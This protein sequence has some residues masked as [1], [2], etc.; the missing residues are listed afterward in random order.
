ML[1]CR[2]VRLRISYRTWPQI[3][4][5]FTR[6]LPPNHT[7]TKYEC[8]IGR[9]SGRPFAAVTACLD[10]STHSHLLKNPAEV[11]GNPSNQMHVLPLYRVTAPPSLSSL[12]PGLKLN[13]HY[14][15]ISA[16]LDSDDDDEVQGQSR[17]EVRGQSH[18]EV[19]GQSSYEIQAK[20]GFE[21]NNQPGY[22]AKP[23]QIPT[24]A[25]EIHG[26]V[27]H[28]PFLGVD[29]G[30]HEYLSPDSSGLGSSIE[31]VES[32]MPLGNTEVLAMCS[33]SYPL[34]GY[35][36][37]YEGDTSQPD[38]TDQGLSQGLSQGDDLFAEVALSNCDESNTTLNE[39]IP[40]PLDNTSSTLNDSILGP[41]DTSSSTL[42]GSMSGPSEAIIQ[43]VKG[44]ASAKEKQQRVI[45]VLDSIGAE[46]VALG[47]THGSILIECAKKEIHA[48][49][50]LKHPSRLN[51]SRISLVFYQHIALNEPHHAFYTRG[52]E[53]EQKCEA[54]KKA[55]KQRAAENNQARDGS[56]LPDKEDS[57][58]QIGQ[59][60][61][62]SPPK[63][64]SPSPPKLSST[65][66]KKSVLSKTTAAKNTPLS[67]DGTQMESQMSHDESFTPV[68]IPRLPESDTQ[69]VL[70]RHADNSLR[71]LEPGY[72]AQSPAVSLTLTSP[73]LPF[74]PPVENNSAFPSSGQ[75][76][77]DP[78]ANSSRQC[79]FPV[80]ASPVNLFSDHI[81][82]I[83][84]PYLGVNGQNTGHMNA[85]Q[86]IPYP[87]PYPIAPEFAYRRQK[88]PI[89]FSAYP[90]GYYSP[91]QLRQ[92][93]VP[94][95]AAQTMQ[96]QLSVHGSGAYPAAGQ[97]KQPRVDNL[98]QPS[99]PIIRSAPLPGIRQFYY[100]QS[101]DASMS[102]DTDSLFSL[103]WHDAYNSGGNEFNAT[104]R[105]N[106]MGS[107]STSEETSDAEVMQYE[108]PATLQQQ[109]QQQQHQLIQNMSHRNQIRQFMT[110][111]TNAAQ[112]QTPVVPGIQQQQQLMQIFPQ[113]HQDHT[114]YT[115]TV[116]A[117]TPIMPGFQQQQQQ[118]FQ[119]V[120][121]RDQ[122]HQ[123]ITN[124]ADTA[125]AETPIVSGFQQQQQQLIQTIPQ[126]HQD[127]QSVTNYKEQ[128]QTATVLGLQSAPPSEA[129][130]NT[131]SSRSLTLGQSYQEIPS[132]Q[133]PYGRVPTI[134]SPQGHSQSTSLYLQSQG[135]S[136]QSVP[137]ARLD[138][139][140]QPIP[141]SQ[142]AYQHMSTTVQ[143]SQDGYSSGS[144]GPGSL[145]SI[146]NPSSYA[147]LLHPNGMSQPVGYNQPSVARW[148][149]PYSFCFVPSNA[150]KLNHQVPGVIPQR[151]AVGSAVTQTHSNSFPR[152]QFQFSGQGTVPTT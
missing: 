82:A 105:A 58:S 38:W 114:N 50:G 78:I 125:Q 112:A 71:Y 54:T 73:N 40:G 149:N 51:P 63:K 135:D 15:I 96:S 100:G 127:H 94:M 129:S 139:P 123:S 65:P 31:S 7:R 11:S 52:V 69:W 104:A 76:V 151:N 37:G 47:L 113:N 19:R 23:S 106:T 108:T 99:T 83:C 90:M 102:S 59:Q 98:L 79:P 48:T 72:P 10:Y 128:A 42:N 138:Q 53:L 109:Q 84:P 12:Q 87:T 146:R 75:A 4:L 16:E 93:L 132:S 148:F 91:L 130:C 117:Q 68:S 61:S 3:L 2:E 49:T 133:L 126:S 124:Y 14:G 27:P 97:R 60:K 8:R 152:P 150:S 18:Y 46:G 118:L 55:K 145:G 21:F 13:K 6:N 110:N 62:A 144:D 29:E 36:Y 67:Q 30:H 43:S 103:L 57:P 136:S 121:Q 77:S 70:N 34:N 32:A 44:S 74:P 89:H 20:V 120:P 22:E 143:P 17:D 64:K 116:E 41:L 122:D 26:E 107:F 92:E 35:D 5:L 142:L 80:E 119:T 25:N 56:Q 134:P 9:V 66:R 86:S 33:E 24:S 28:G 45:K 81:R 131:Q 101:S 95:A 111:Y 39:S 137:P 147:Q 141:S 85:V 140:Y 88:T 1:T 115:N